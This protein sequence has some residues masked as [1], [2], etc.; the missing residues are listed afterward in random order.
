M[1]EYLAAAGLAMGGIIH[2]FGLLIYH[3][4]PKE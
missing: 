2:G 4:P 1:K 3:I